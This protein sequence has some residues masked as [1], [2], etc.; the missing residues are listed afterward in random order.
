MDSPIKD[1]ICQ[2]DTLYKALNE[3]KHDVIWKDSVAGF[4]KN[5]LK[6]IYSLIEDI[7][8][9]T[10][11]LQPYTYFKVYEPKERDIVSTRIRDRVFQRA[12]CNTYLYKEMTKSFIYDNC[13]CQLGKGNEF[14]RKRL[15][16]HLQ[17]YSRKHGING[18]V[19]KIDIKNFFGS[20]SHKLAY[21]TVCNRVDDL[22]VR[23]IV[24]DVIDSYNNGP[25]PDIGM[26][27]GSELTQLIQLAILDTLDHIIKEQLHIR[28]YLRY[29]DDMII[30][31][32]DI[33]Y[34]R[35]CKD[36]ISSWLMNAGL[37]IHTKKT[38][39]FPITHGIR[40][41]GY[42]YRLTETCKVVMTLL[43]EKVSHERRK[44][45][46]LVKRYTQGMMTKSHVDRCYAAW[47]SCTGNQ[48][49]PN[50][51]RR[52]AHRNTHNLI[53]MIDQFYKSL[54]KGVSICSDTSLYMN[55]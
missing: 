55:N 23:K 53:L 15:I 19:L 51:H 20:T 4:V 1:Q 33:S 40:F 25:D 24:K 16:C 9:D 10:Y 42:R 34:L 30:L 22:W 12:L 8:N 6:N 2:F 27:L 43:H 50:T 45:R 48:H 14:A 32:N 7:Q 38:Q 28:H 52:K 41:I 17:K 11:K 29:N 39:I 44:L 21:E 46:R 47:K 18:F 54:W 49:R 37:H 36:I 26:G 31:H 35:Y 13:A 3:C 5:G